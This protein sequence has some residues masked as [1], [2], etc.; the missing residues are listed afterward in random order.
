[1]SIKNGSGFSGASAEG[2]RA[3]SPLP[4]PFLSI[5]RFDLPIANNFLGQLRIIFR[6]GRMRI[7]EQYRFSV[8]RT[9]AQ[10]HIAIDYG[11]KDL[12]RKILPRFFRHLMRETVSGIEHGKQNS[13]ERK[14]RVQGLLYQL[15]SFQESAQTLQG[16]IFA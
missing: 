13:F 4:S 14:S 6:S 9:L 5:T 8:A 7:V 12:P 3:L 1:M 11:V 2:M 15:E 16:V 10:A